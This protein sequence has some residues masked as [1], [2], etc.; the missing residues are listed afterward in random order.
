MNQTAPTNRNTMKNGVSDGGPN[1]SA[2]ILGPHQSVLA[3]VSVSGPASRLG[4][5]RAKRYAPAVLEAARE[6]ETALGLDSA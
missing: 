1:R 6:I 3:V 2:P 5:L 4:R